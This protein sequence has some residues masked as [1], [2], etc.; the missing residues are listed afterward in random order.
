MEE[1]LITP[2]S[3]YIIFPYQALLHG[4]KSVLLLAMK[5]AMLKCLFKIAGIIGTHKESKP[6]LWSRGKR[7]TGVD[8]DTGS[9]KYARNSDLW[10]PSR[11]LL[12]LL[13]QSI[14]PIMVKGSDLA[15][16]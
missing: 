1:D 13:L 15:C 2:F 9:S 11:S 10:V 14:A 4:Q 6:N 3:L 16:Q 7:D 12:S 5:T 8:G